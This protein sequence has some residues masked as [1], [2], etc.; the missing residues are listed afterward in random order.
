V[1]GNGDEEFLGIAER[2][3]PRQQLV[4]LVGV[5][6]AETLAGRYHAINW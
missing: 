1:V 5:R 2:L 6:G 3:T 4:D